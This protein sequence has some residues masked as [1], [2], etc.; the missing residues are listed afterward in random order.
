MTGALLTPPIS[1]AEPREWSPPAPAAPPGRPPLGERLVKAG[2]ISA[3]HLDAALKQ[4]AAKRTRLGETLVELGFVEEDEL[5]PYLEQ[6]LASPAVRLRDGVIDPEVVR[7]LP[8]PVAERFDAIALFRVRGALTV[9]MAEPQNLEQIDEI[10]R[11]TGLRVSPVFAVRS[12]IR[13]ML[14][15]CYEEDFAVD[16]VTAD[17]D[18]SAV[19]VSVDSIQLDAGAV[20]SLADGSPIINLV[21]YLIVSAVRQRASDIHIEP[22]RKHSVVR[23]RVDGLLREVLRPRAEF[24]PAIVSRIKVMAKLDIA[25][26]RS[27]QDG[28][29]HVAVE[30][31]SIDLRV[32]TLPTVL[33]EKVVLRVLDRRNV[34][35][36]LD[37]LGVPPHQLAPVKEMLG[38]PHGIVLVTGPTGSG[39][40]TTLYSALELIKS[41]HRNIVT[42]EDPVEYQLEQ[43]NQVHADPHGGISFA[44]A[45]RAILRQDPDVIMVGEIRDGETAEVAVQAALT[46]HLV[47]S[48]LHT[49]D[50]AGA[51]TRLLDMGL[52]SYKIA[53]ALAGVVAQ[54]L[55]RKVCPHCK[56]H[57]YPDRALLDAVRYQGDRRRQFVRGEGCDRCHDTG[58]EGRIGIY[59]VLTCPR[60]LRELIVADPNVERLREWHR[61][62]GGTTLLDEGIA[63]AE[64]GL[65]SLDE[66]LRVAWSD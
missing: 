46:G 42:V 15:R 57:Y 8:R 7:T 49:N 64:R 24:H 65:T 2:L 34:T 16:A 3:D 58:F 47:L 61:R 36:D 44:Q 41:V 32:S 52:A 26:R 43:V 4:G 51:I 12:A 27:A 50:S 10:E 13:R 55:V 25:E 62:Q 20:E 23:L 60:E 59:E 14:P 1:D 66:V 28:R 18:Q 40:T 31:G 33:G 29:I 22:G 6:Q 54:R 48:T 9:A 45:L 39:K 5:L 53:A 37:R 17:L 30:G 63:L 21:N 11:V 19:D 35:F 38:R 56:M